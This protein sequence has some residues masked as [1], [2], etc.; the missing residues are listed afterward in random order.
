MIRKIA[1]GL[2]AT[3]I[4][5]GAATMSASAAHGGPRGG[6]GYSKGGMGKMG[7][8]RGMYRSGPR[9]FAYR[10]PGRSDHWRYHHHWGPRWGHYERPYYYGGGGGSCWRKVWTPSGWDREW[11]CGYGRPY[12]YSTRS[13]GNYRG[14]GYGRPHGHRR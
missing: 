3:V 2:A 12:G 6:M 8:S 5:T 13:Y 10:A 7:M 14:G 11:V 4:A 1:I 9:T